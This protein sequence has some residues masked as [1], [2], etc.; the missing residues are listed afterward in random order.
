MADAPRTALSADEALALWKRLFDASDP[1]ATSDFA[2]AFFEPL[3]DWLIKHNP[4]AHPHDCE[5]AAED[6]I[7]AVIKNPA[8]YQ[9]ERQ[10]LVAYLRMS[11]KRDLLNIQRS[12]ERHRGRRA[13][14]E[15]VELSPKLGKYL[16]DRDA[17]PAVVVERREALAAALR[18]RAPPAAMLAGLTAR[19]L[20]V[21][22][23]MQTGERRTSVY[24][25]A[26]GIEEWPPEEQR[27][28][29]KR[30]KDRLAKRNE[31]AGG[32]RA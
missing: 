19:E 16:Q 25:H 4:R 12:E 6:T 29:V 1:T 20:R 27:R 31:R 15:A 26:L 13:N 10:T 7:L 28:E 3:A 9:P 30:V 24:A 22:E 8:S 17:D 14:L 18:G 5:T 23:L 2:V 11:A 21:F 32:S